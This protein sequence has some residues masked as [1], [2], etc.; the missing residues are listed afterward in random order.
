[1]RH[2]APWN[3]ESPPFGTVSNPFVSVYGYKAMWQLNR[4]PEGVAR[5]ATAVDLREGLVAE[6]PPIVRALLP[7]PITASF[8][9]EIAET[10]SAEGP[11]EASTSALRLADRVESASD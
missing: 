8:L 5:L 4:I 3:C 7:S 11:Q 1:M 9:R 6:L 10:L 2:S